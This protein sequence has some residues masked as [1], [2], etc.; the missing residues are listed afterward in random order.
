MLADLRALIAQSTQVAALTDVVGLGVRPQASRAPA[1]VLNIVSE[2][3]D[4]TYAGSVELLR[5]RVQIDLYADSSV[6]AAPLDAAVVALLDG[7]R[8]VAGGTRFEGVFLISRTDIPVEAAVGG[9][10]YRISRDLM[11]NHKEA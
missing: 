5:T 7:Y 10:L 9:P 6:Q 2:Q 3:R 4:Y 1:L 11:V 8:G